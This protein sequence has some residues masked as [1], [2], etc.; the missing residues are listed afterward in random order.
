MNRGFRVL[1]RLF[2]F[3]MVDLELLSA[4]ALG[5]T[6]KLLGQFASL[7]IFVGFLLSF[8][9][10][11]FV[12]MKIAPEAGFAFTLYME[13]LLKATTMLVVGIFAVLSWD[14]IFPDRRDVLI[15]MPLPLRARTIFLAK[16]A[17]TASALSLVVLLF[18]CAAG[19]T[20][21]LAFDV[22]A[23]PHI[24]P[25]LTFDPALPPLSA[26][27]LKPELDQALQQSVASGWLRPGSGGGLVIGVSKQGERR[28]FTYGVG[29]AD[30]V[31]EIGS[32]SKT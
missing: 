23:E 4:H 13:H 30:S 19:L 21:P 11:S 28:I 18:H 6:N 10:L 27:D 12:D 32:I 20:W 31:F 17:A 8:P 14:L 1:Y 24:A 26:S 2:L 15:L 29:K 7:L 9:A 22:Q 3:R 16:L 25:S 5:D